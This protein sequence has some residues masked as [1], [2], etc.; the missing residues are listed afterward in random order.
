[1]TIADPM[2]KRC[3]C[4][5]FAQTKGEKEELHTLIINI[6]QVS[7]W[8]DFLT[9]ESNKLQLTQHL[10]DFLLL[11]DSTL[12]RDIFVTI[13]GICV[14]AFRQNRNRS[15]VQFQSCFPIGEKQPF[16]C[17]FPLCIQQQPITPG[18]GGGTQ[19]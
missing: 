12:G 16:A 8:N 14:T 15:N 7:E 18:G 5:K 1:M 9:N 17:F 13:R 19:L 4:L 3:I 6:P 2:A 10:A 11:D